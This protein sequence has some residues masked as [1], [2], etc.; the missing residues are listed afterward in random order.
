MSARPPVLPWRGWGTLCV[1]LKGVREPRPEHTRFAEIRWPET[2]VDQRAVELCADDQMNSNRIGAQVLRALSRARIGILTMALTYVLGVVCGALMVHAGNEFA[3]AYR[4]RLVTRARAG[5]PALIA[6]R[7]GDRFTAALWD[8]GGNLLRGAVPSTIAGLS[9]V[10][11]YPLAAFRGWI[12]GIVSVDSAHLSRLAQPGEALYYSLT[13]MLQ[14]IPY[15]LAGGAGVTLGIACLRPQPFYR[16]DRWLGVP[17]EAIR[18]V[19]RIYL[20]VTPLFF[21][22]SMWEFLAR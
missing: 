11:P 18:D 8:F 17:K 15:S 19:F 9:V 12:G 10:F 22:A 21:V 16:G 20:L 3:L 2:A 7:Q 6:L 1:D 4:D 14:L 5:E 13:L